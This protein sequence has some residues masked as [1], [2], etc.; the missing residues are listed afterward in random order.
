MYCENTGKYVN[1]N[2]DF[3]W[4]ITTLMFGGFSVLENELKLYDNG[5]SCI[6]NTC[7]LLK[8]DYPNPSH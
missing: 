6:K 5:Y 2:S 1:I 7:L 3:C 4:T 8:Q